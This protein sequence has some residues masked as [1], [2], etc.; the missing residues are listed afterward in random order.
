MNPDEDDD[1]PHSRTVL[2][3]LFE[4][5]DLMLPGSFQKSKFEITLGCKDRFGDV[6]EG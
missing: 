4:G 3:Q 6:A 5:E 1:Y 2:P